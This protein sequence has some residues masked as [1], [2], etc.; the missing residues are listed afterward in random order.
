MSFADRLRGITL[1]IGSEIEKSSWWK[2]VQEYL[3]KRAKEGSVAYLSGSVM[4]KGSLSIAEVD[5]RVKFLQSHE[6]K[7]EPF[8]LK[9]REGDEFQD[10]YKVSW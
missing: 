10:G 3:E 9:D 7:L 6:L 2:E 5:A 8:Y 4:S 1:N